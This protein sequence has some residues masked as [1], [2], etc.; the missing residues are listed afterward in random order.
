MFMPFIETGDGT[1]IF[2][3]D[4][5]IGKPVVFSHGWCLGADIWEYQMVPLASQGL[6]CI[7]HDRRGCG[8][9]SQPW[10]GHDHDTM[11]DDLARL[12]DRLDLREVTLVG[13]SMGGSDIAR[14][15]SRH[16]TGRVARVALVATTLPFLTRTADNPDGI[17]RGVFDQ[18]IADLTRDRPR[19]MAA[20]APGFFGVGLP[21]VSVS[22]EMIQWGIGL[23][24][25]ASPRATIEMQ[26]AGAETD[27]RPDLRSFTVPTLLVHGDGDVGA[28]LELTAARVARAIP[29]SQLLVYEGHGHGL[30]LTAPDR[31]NRDLLAFIGGQSASE[32][33]HSSVA[34]SAGK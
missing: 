21:G 15:L 17:D 14:Y 34:L 6:R 30:F 4:W 23:A 3:K 32:R 2:Y 1:A 12:L 19:T 10:N 28:P 24:L 5:G 11:A 26:R 13:H 31:F 22:D 29:G 18:L 25:Q 27:L 16:G 9:S 20:G 7:A 8:R 33:T